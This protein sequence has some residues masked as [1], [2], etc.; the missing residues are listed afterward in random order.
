MEQ[1]L[2]SLIYTKNIDDNG[3]PFTPQLVE[4]AVIG[5]NNKIQVR[6]NI[7]KANGVEFLS[8][9]GLRR[10]DRP[11]LTYSNTNCY[12]LYESRGEVLFS[13][14]I[15]GTVV[16]RYYG[17]GNPN[18]G[19]CRV[20]TTIDNN[21]NIKET[22]NSTILDG[23]EIIDELIA[24]GGGIVVLNEL[25]VAISNADSLNT[26]LGTKIVT[27]N[28]LNNELKGNIDKGTP[29]NNSLKDL[30]PRGES[31]NPS[32]RDLVPRGETVKRDLEI[33]VPKGEDLVQSIR[34]SDNKSKTI[35]PGDWVKNNTTKKYEYTWNH[36]MNSS[37]IVFCFTQVEGGSRVG[38][39]VD[40]ILVNNNSTKF[41]S[42]D[43][44]ETVVVATTRY[45][46]GTI[47]DVSTIEIDRM[48]DGTNKVLMTRE[49]RTKV[50]QIESKMTK[51][52]TISISQIDKNVEKFDESFMSESL[53]QMIAG[54]AP[55]G[56][57]P[58]NGSVT[59]DKVVDKAITVAKM[60]QVPGFVLGK[61][62]L[63]INTVAKEI[64]APQRVWITTQE[65]TYHALNAGTYSW[66]SLNTST[67]VFAFYNKQTLGIEFFTHNTAPKSTGLVYLFSIYL[68]GVTAN[69]Y[70][71]TI[72]GKSLMVTADEIVLNGNKIED[73]SLN[74]TKIIG[75][76]KI[77]CNQLDK[78][79]VTKGFYV[80][81]SDGI[82]KPNASY[83]TSDYIKISPSTKFTVTHR[84]QVAYYDS[85]FKFITGTGTETGMPPIGNPYTFTSPSNTNVSY[86]RVC[87][88]KNFLDIY[89]LC[90]GDQVSKDIS[91]LI[92]LPQV[93]VEGKNINGVIKTEQL[94]QIEKSKNIFNKNNIIDGVFCRYSTGRLDP[95]ATYWTSELIEVEA[96]ESYTTSHKNQLCFYNLDGQYI[97]GIG[98][99]NYL[100]FTFVVPDGVR[101]VRICNTYNYLAIQQL[102]KGTFSTEYMDYEIKLGG[103]IT[104][105]IR[106][107][108][109]VTKSKNL[110]NKKNIAKG[111]YVGF[112]TGNLLD[113]SLY[114]A[115][116]F[117]KVSSR[118]TYCRSSNDQMGFYDKDK[119]FISGFGAKTDPLQFT[120]P[121]NTRFVRI[122]DKL[123]NLDNYQLELGAVPTSFESFDSFSITGMTME[124]DYGRRKPIITL[125]E[126]WRLWEKGERAPI[127]FLSDSTTDGVG[128]TGHQ[129]HIDFDNANGG[130]GKVE[131]ICEKAYPF[132][133]EK[134]VREETKNSNAKV[135]NIGYSGTRT[136]WA[137]TNIEA[138][139]GGAYSD[140]KMVG[141]GHGINDRLVGSNTYEYGQEVYGN[142]K[143]LIEWLL[144]RGIM[145]FMVTTQPTSEAGLRSTDST[146]YP[147]RT[148]EAINS[149]CNNIK[150]QLAQEYGLEI[151]DMNTFGDNIMKNSEYSL[152]EIIP[153][154]LHFGD[155]GHVLEAGFLFSE[156]CP[157][158]I[159]VD[160]KGDILGFSNQRVKTGLFGD[161]LSYTTP[162]YG[163]K[164]KANYT[165]ADS[166]DTMVQDFWII[167]NSKRKISLKS[168]VE[169]VT[170]NTCYVKVDGTSS[171]ITSTEQSLGELEIGLHHIEAFTGATNKANFL[172]FKLV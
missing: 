124:K 40:Y 110:F 36:N 46:T 77:G 93:V 6:Q 35:L 12:F 146:Q 65:G 21:G 97:S 9:K 106:D 116:D 15:K 4:V 52:D 61:D 101:Y 51:G 156:I 95:N 131:Y 121:D 144:N 105:D 1:Y 84:D 103:N 49:E 18:I 132:L 34:Y 29:I 63:N 140:V 59:T 83:V 169:T 90:L 150:R 143:F 111:K 157:R 22:L 43:N 11:E 96:G 5:E 125:Q 55:V 54:N 25:K 128:T 27:G 122:S 10:V 17:T 32:L 92:K 134:L 16:I 74:L 56:Q 91:Y 53:L 58:T 109:G 14:D 99:A 23:R 153:D 66:A 71:C 158:V 3:T 168:Y 20:F 26:S 167:N 139:F 94:D 44:L 8:P 19:D 149:V 151:I 100:P 148:P 73:S 154:R 70:A 75:G 118:T 80:N 85:N 38:A 112:S 127:G 160:E 147:V 88:H 24:L 170:P 165:K 141:L 162:I 172:G 145:P 2:D 64:V 107:I 119:K 82:A 89:A 78:F 137:I 136:A 115:S 42:S 7:Y 48:T 166:V 126:V 108:K 30:V 67:M 76:E 79:S 31:I 142:F 98:S 13:K 68:G 102:E 28:S 159:G 114:F 135:Y 133:L 161:K 72:N 171:V 104:T 152:S 62:V 164:I 37:T 163:F 45:Y 117:I 69:G 33:E 129:K 39:I 47:G 120:T 41:I 113:N 57:T 155:I 50:A 138:L 130:I 87:F 123:T 81:F 60:G 86:V